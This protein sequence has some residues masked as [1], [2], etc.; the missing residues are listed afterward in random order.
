MLVKAVEKKRSI[1][2]RESREREEQESRERQERENREREEKRAMIQKRVDQARKAQESSEA[3]SCSQT[4]CSSLSVKSGDCTKASDC[5]SKETNDEVECRLKLQ[6]KKINRKKL[7]GQRKCVSK[8]YSSCA[9][10]AVKDASSD[11]SSV[12]T[13]DLVKSGMKVL[14]ESDTESS[15]SESELSERCCDKTPGDYSIGDSEKCIKDL[16]LR[17]SKNPSILKQNWVNRCSDIRSCDSKGGNW[18]VDS[19]TCSL[20]RV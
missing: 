15:S 20:R 8:S 19:K 11:E 10:L 12:D 5:C 18:V 14:G 9:K 3:S 6:G 1:K 2:E 13:L 16:N 4:D 7:K 17:N